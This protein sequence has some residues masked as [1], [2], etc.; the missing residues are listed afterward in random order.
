MIISTKIGQTSFISEEGKRLNA[1]VLDYSSCIVVGNRTEEKDGYIANIIGYLKPKK[2]NNPQ[3]KE[4]NKKNI[5]PRK[6]VK[7]HRLENA[8]NLIEI[9][10]EVNP[11]FQVS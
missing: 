10:S 3:L 8:E 11:S 1:T 7:E 2:L 9:G 4:F 6:H 5:E